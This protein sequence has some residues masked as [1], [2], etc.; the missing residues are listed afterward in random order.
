[1]QAVVDEHLSLAAQLEGRVI[2][3]AGPRQIRDA[4]NS[5][6]DIERL[7]LEPA[8]RGRRSSQWSGLAEGHL[9]ITIQVYGSILRRYH[10]MLRPGLTIETVP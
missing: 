5:F 6:S 1:M 7:Y 2:G 10:A 4:V 8:R 9:A 3:E